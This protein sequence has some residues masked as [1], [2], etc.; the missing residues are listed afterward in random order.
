MLIKKQWAKVLNLHLHRHHNRSENSW[1][2]I[3]HVVNV[4]Q[5]STR[6]AMPWKDPFGAVRLL[7][8]TFS[9]ITALVIVGICSPFRK[10]I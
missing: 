9:V 7:S 3:Q 10:W 2:T 6:T 8:V 1:R 4:N 5:P